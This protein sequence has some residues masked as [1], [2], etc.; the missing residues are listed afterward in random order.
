MK[1]ALVDNV[2]VEATKG[3]K[4]ICPVCNKELIAKCGEIKINHWA[5]KKISDCDQWWENETEWHRSWKNHFPAEWQEIILPDEQTGEKH[6][7]D[8]RTI[9]GLVIEFQHSKIDKQERIKR[10]KHYKR[11]IWVVDGMRA[12]RDYPDFVKGKKY[13]RKTTKENFYLIDYPETCFPADWLESSVPV[14]FDYRGTEPQ[15][16]LD[17][18]KN[19]LYCLLPKQPN[20]REVTLAKISRVDFVNNIINDIWFKKTEPQKQI[21]KVPVRRGIVIK[22]PV[23]QYDFDPRKGRFVKRRRF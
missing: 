16:N 12:R 5:H 6:I 9:H 23:P 22:R 8:V 3:A 15:D 18:T 21:V 17:D 13:F 4:G 2:K 11:M 19:H 14:I 20:K 1:F 10:E 7:A